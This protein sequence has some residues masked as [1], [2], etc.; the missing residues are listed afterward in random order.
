[1]SYCTAA[2]VGTHQFL[3]AAFDLW[4]LENQM[5]EEIMYGII[6]A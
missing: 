6:K 2:P 4:S 3:D 5:P 1:M